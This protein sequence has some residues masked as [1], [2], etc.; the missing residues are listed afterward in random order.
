MHAFSQEGSNP[1]QTVPAPPLAAGMGLSCLLLYRWAPHLWQVLQLNFYHANQW[2]M[3]CQMTQALS[4][5]TCRG[6]REGEPP[7]GTAKERRNLRRSSPPPDITPGHPS[8]HCEGKMSN[9]MAACVYDFI[10]CIRTD[11]QL[12]LALSFSKHFT[13]FVFLCCAEQMDGMKEESRKTLGL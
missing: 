11:S 9:N 12:L 1:S 5:L 13:L 6:G 2:Q 7:R 8:H 3:H 10:R 4:F